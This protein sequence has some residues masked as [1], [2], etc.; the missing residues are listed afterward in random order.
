MSRHFAPAQASADVGRTTGN[1]PAN[2][3]VTASY[4]PDFERCRLLCETIDRQVTGF[5]SHYI[6]VEGRDVALFRQLETSRRIVVDERDL[7]PSWLRPFDD[8][9]SRGRRVW[10][11]W[12]SM[13]L[14][15]WHAQQ[16]RRIGIAAHVA[17][18]AL[19]FCDS[20]VAFLKPFDC[21]AFW[22]DGRLRLLRR[23]N[24]LTSPP[25]ADHLTWSRNAGIVLGIEPPQLSL[26]DYISTV[27]AWK[28]STVVDMCA[29]IQKVRGVNWVAAIAA[30][31]KFSECIIY[32]RYVDEII[33]G[34]GHFPSAKEFCRV[35]WDGQPMDDGQ[36]R[37]FVAS[38]QPGQVA[39]G[40][41]SFI[42]TDLSRIRQLIGENPA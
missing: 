11:S 8:P 10:L 3:L 29:H 24:A 34:E 28:R 15:G 1:T 13:P 41:Q 35:H 16:L 17:D 36:F 12:R 42:G 20:D 7:L 19:V 38:M 4:A 37:A 6:L 26:H 18:D 27:I 39:I 30:R 32:G 31:R 33:G 40:M 2:A 23:D 22:N 14:R 21:G 25:T 5:S 9:F